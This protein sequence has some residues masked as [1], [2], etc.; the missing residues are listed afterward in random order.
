MIVS[1][2]LDF[3][4]ESHKDHKED[5]EN[6][7]QNSQRPKGFQEYYLPSRVIQSNNALKLLLID[8]GRNDGI[9]VGELLDIFEP[10]HSDGTFGAVLGR[11]RVLE[12]GPTRSKIQVL[13]FFKQAPN[14]GNPKIEEGFVVRRPVR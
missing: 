8:K 14:G 12:V 7:A 13:D 5:K 11:G 10:N 6:V 1:L 4:K 2:G 9:T 3:G